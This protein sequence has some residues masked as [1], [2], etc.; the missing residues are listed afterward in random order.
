MKVVLSLHA[1]MRVSVCE[2]V[3]GSGS[4]KAHPRLSWEQRGLPWPSLPFDTP[5]YRF[6][7]LLMRFEIFFQSKH[8]LLYVHV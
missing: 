2:F 8:I 6:N 5:L 1:C 7:L 4:L 3:H